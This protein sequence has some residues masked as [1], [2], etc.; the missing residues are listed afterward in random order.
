MRDIGI[1][2]QYRYLQNVG[3]LDG[4][5]RKRFL[6]IWS[7]GTALVVSGS[8]ANSTIVCL[9]HSDNP[10]EAWVCNSFFINSWTSKTLDIGYQGWRISLFMPRLYFQTGFTALYLA[11]WTEALWFQLEIGPFEIGE[12][13]HHD[14]GAVSATQLIAVV[15]DEGIPNT[16]TP[17]P[18]VCFSWQWPDLINSKFSR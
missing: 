18:V 4:R 10:S 12:I 6:S 13:L 2:D 8:K 16:S 11:I 5:P 15:G 14:L 9:L 17:V 3:N 7:A 1:G